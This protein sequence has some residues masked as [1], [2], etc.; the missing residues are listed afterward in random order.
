MNETLWPQKQFVTFLLVAVPKA[1][2]RQHN[3][4]RDLI[5]YLQST[6]TLVE[7]DFVQFPSNGHDAITGQVFDLLT[8]RGTGADAICLCPKLEAI[9][10]LGGR[11]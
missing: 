9:R 5:E 4:A 11:I 3:G 8:Y 1:Q 10:M 2:E 6:P 7:L